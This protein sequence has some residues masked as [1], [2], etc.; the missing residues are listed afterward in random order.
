M[1]DKVHE[2]ERYWYEYVF[3]WILEASSS[4]KTEIN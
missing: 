4:M 3:T 2:F 1:Y